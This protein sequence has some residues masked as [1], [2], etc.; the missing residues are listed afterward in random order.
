M[1]GEQIACARATWMVNI[2]GLD[3]L[4]WFPLLCVTNIANAV[5]YLKLLNNDYISKMQ[6]KE[7]NCVNLGCCSVHIVHIHLS[8]KYILS[9][10][11]DW[12]QYFYHVF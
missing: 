8:I 3:V 4:L 7:F 12:L 9:G 6:E 5:T 10:P 2:P 1:F 11:K